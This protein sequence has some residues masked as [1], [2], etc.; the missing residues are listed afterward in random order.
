MRFSCTQENLNAGLHAV[1]H[2][3]SKST[4]LP[5]LSNVLISA[6]GG[7]IVL[8]TTNLEM[9]VSCTV[10]GKVEDEG[11]FTVQSKLLA[12]FV[13]L[14]GSGKVDVQLTD[15]VIEVRGE[16]SHTK[17]K[18][19]HAD[20][21]PVIPQIRKQNGYSMAAQDLVNAL[22]QVAFAA[23][24]SESRPEISG[25]YCHF[26]EKTL[27]LAATDSYRL[28]EK[29]IA[30]ENKGG[31]EREVI[32]PARTVAELGR[33]LSG[34]AGKEDAAVVEIYFEDNQVV[35][36]CGDVELVSR[37]IEGQYPNYAQIIP[38]T[39]ATRITADTAA[40][41][42]AVRT[43]ALFSRTGIFD[44]TLEL[45][46]GG[47][48]VRATNANLGENT[49]QFE[50]AV[51]GADVSIVLNY[52]YLLDGLQNVGT[53]QIQFD[54]TDASTATILRPAGGDEARAAAGS[55]TYLIMPI[56]Q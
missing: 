48:T 37:I 17:M 15:D 20:E 49:S 54:L 32:L 13:H 9:G 45:K 3:A 41:I 50:A 46:Q 23:S 28:A 31:N 18:G 5:I 7:A 25:V 56:R 35:C 33:I 27:T 1:S 6:K 52:R 36:T 12:D 10:R 2:I 8:T 22:S 29:V 43:A 21:F 44:I 40:L 47:C 16:R 19:N 4:T 42:A 26:Q 30:I 55:Y 51:D 39:R 34:P 11:V 53:A 38:V 24:I 14:L